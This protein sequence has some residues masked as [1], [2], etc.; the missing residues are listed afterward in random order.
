M[1]CHP[2]RPGNQR[3]YPLPWHSLGLFDD[4][5]VREACTQGLAARYAPLMRMLEAQGA[6]RPARVQVER[7]PTRWT[8]RTQLP[9]QRVQAHAAWCSE[10][11]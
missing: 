3:A 10:G 1:L 2:W 6:Q 7:Q 9:G 11:D 5:R 8:W 4:S